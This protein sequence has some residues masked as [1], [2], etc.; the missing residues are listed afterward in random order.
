VLAS[1]VY[2]GDLSGQLKCA[3]DRTYS[4]LNPDYSCRLQPG[5]KVVMVLAQANPEPAEFEDIY[6]RYQRW[7]NWYGFAGSHLLRAVGVSEAGEVKGQAAVLE[8][9]AALARELVG[10]S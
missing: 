5:K 10:K 4:Y 6:P 9:A 7:F 1:P 2:Y 8:Q 3:F